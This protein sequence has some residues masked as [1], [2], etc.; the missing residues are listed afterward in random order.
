MDEVLTID[1]IKARYAPDWVLIG[2]PRTDEF[3]RLHAGKVLFHSPDR[4]AVYRKAGEL[5]PGHF[6]FRYL[7]ELPQD[8]AFVL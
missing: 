8:M 7:G 5:Q 6:A 4:E 3:Q 1:E 2:E